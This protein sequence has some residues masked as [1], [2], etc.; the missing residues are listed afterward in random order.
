MKCGKKKLKI[1]QGAIN[2]VNDLYQDILFIPL[3]E[4]FLR[5]WWRK[6]QSLWWNFRWV[7]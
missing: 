2:S 7:L 5:K 6:L 3:C 1:T 4:T